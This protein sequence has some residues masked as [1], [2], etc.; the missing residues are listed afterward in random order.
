M[1]ELNRISVEES[2]PTRTTIKKDWID[3]AAV[4]LPPTVLALGGTYH[5]QQG[6]WESGEVLF[7]MSERII[8]INPTFYDNPDIGVYISVADRVISP[9]IPKVENAVLNLAFGG[10]YLSTTVMILVHYKLKSIKRAVRF[11]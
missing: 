1:T 11:V 8:E 5:L 3:A 2:K 10:L 4:A 7:E 6:L 9:S